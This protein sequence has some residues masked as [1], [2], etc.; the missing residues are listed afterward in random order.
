VEHGALTIRNGFTHFPQKQELYRF[1]AGEP[2]I[3]ARIIIQE[4]SGNIS[5]DV[6]SWLAQQNVSLI[7][8]DWRG[9]IQCVV[10]QSGYAANPYRVGWQRETRSD[11]GKRLKFSI[12]KITRKI[13]SSILTLE[14]AVTKSGAW[15]KAMEAA[16]SSLAKLDASEPKTIL[17]LR[18]LEANAAAAYFR[19]WR[20][21]PI[22]WRG[23][24]RRP[25]PET[26]KKIGQRTSLFHRAG[27]RNSSHPVNSI[28]N[29]GYTIL[30][31]QLQIQ[32]TAEGYDPTIGIMH[33]ENN[34]SAAFIFDMMEPHRPAVDRKILEFLRRNVF[35]PGDFVIRS[36][37]VC[38]LNPAMA[39]CVAG[40]LD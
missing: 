16:Y 13:E 22:K 26:W 18:A 11:P 34:G 12:K 1:F 33:E 40:L 6:L 25:I 5:L 30:Q 10:A 4:G 23:T 35:D 2:D 29:Y 36:D 38:R 39:R 15:N 19:A 37:G 32:L 21:T 20:G 7:R 24:S 14:K 17:E 31:S 3:P 28:L 8:I 9:N 27:N